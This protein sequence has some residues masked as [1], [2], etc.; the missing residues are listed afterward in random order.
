MRRGEG[1]RIIGAPMTP[2]RLK[3]MA[4]LAAL[5]AVFLCYEVL[6]KFDDWNR[7]QSCATTGRRNCDR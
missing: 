2:D 6:V 3:L 5:V 7:L 1:T 4:I